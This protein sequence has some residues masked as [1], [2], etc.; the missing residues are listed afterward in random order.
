MRKRSLY[1]LGWVVLLFLF[2]AITLPITLQI[3]EKFH[4]DH[5][6]I[7]KGIP[8]ILQR[9]ESDDVSC[10][11]SGM[12]KTVTLTR[13]QLKTLNNCLKKL[14][15]DANIKIYAPS[16]HKIKPE[17]SI[18][19]DGKQGDKQPLLMIFIYVNMNMIEMRYDN[20]EL[21]FTL[22]K[23]DLLQLMAVVLELY[24]SKDLKSLVDS[25]RQTRK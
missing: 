21:V 5:L 10:T 22:E 15:R 1:R 8:E 2:I 4:P 9:I 25:I 7:A 11:I 19:Y 18:T 13:E 23:Q 14:S 16:S 24:P 12:G 3:R 17:C 6:I 20:E